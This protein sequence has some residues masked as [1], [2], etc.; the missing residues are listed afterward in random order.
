[1]ERVWWAAARAGDGES[2]GCVFDLHQGRVYRHA[3]RLVDRRADAEDVTAAAFLELWRRREDVRLVE[4]SVLPWLLVTA[5]NVSRNLRRSTRRHRALLD[6]LPRA[7]SAAD[8]AEILSERST[9]GWDPALLGHLRSLATN[10]LALVSLVVLEGFA[11]AEAAEALDL[12]E[13]AAKSRLYRFR[14]AARACTALA[15]GG[16]ET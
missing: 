12:S 9:F 11:I 14:R 6:R 16:N 5:T 1:M 8:P 10:N 4:G 15:A 2:F 7:G 3:C 13:S